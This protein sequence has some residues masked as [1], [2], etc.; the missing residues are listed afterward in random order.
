MFYGQTPLATGSGFFWKSGTRKFLVSNWHNFAGRN[1]HTGQP[2]APHGGIPDVVRFWSYKQ[3]GDEFDGGMFRLLYVPVVVQLRDASSTPQWI[4]HATHGRRVDI[5]ALDVTEHLADM[6][7]MFVNEVE[8]DVQHTKFKPMEDLFVIGYPFGRSLNTIS[9]IYKRA[10]IAVDPELEIDNLPKML[11]D[12][13]TR[14]GM[15]GSV[16]VS[17]HLFWGGKLLKKNGSEA[18]PVML[19]EHQVVA[20]I[21]A[22][23]HYADLEKFQLGVVYKRSAIE[24][25]VAAGVA[26]AP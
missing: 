23:R 25:V 11:V 1:P 16:V 14:E 9:P 22:G 2:I 12:T 15:S 4:E 13:A 8:A 26:P 17:K 5:A 19:A 20:G 18:E 24:D 7:T 6:R 21:Y 3:V 10:S